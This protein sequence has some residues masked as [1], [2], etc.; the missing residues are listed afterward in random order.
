MPAVLYSF[1][2]SEDAAYVLANLDVV[3][4]KEILSNRHDHSGHPIGLLESKI[5]YKH[6]KIGRL[7][8]KY[9]YG[10][11]GVFM[12]N[13]DSMILTQTLGEIQLHEGMR[14]DDVKKAVFEKDLELERQGKRAWPQKVGDK[15]KFVGRRWVTTKRIQG[16]YIPES[17]ADSVD[18][19]IDSEDH[20]FNGEFDLDSLPVLKYVWERTKELRDN[21]GANWYPKFSDTEIT[22][23]CGFDDDRVADATEDLLG[24]LAEA[25]YPRTARAPY[26]RVFLPTSRHE[27]VESALEAE[28][29][30]GDDQQKGRTRPIEISLGPFQMNK[31]KQ[32]A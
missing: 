4:R 10:I 25:Y 23:V 27:I 7:L 26:R 28:R 11:V 32:V 17:I 18:K 29:T 21:Y 22:R 31:D 30:L 19:T 8:R 1:P 9:L 20:T 16:L 13:F 3:G 12:E 14:L 15:I 24:L 6:E 5:E 2:I